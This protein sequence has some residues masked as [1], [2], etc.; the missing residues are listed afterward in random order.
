M[1]GS[2]LK[3]AARTWLQSKGRHWTEWSYARFCTELRAAVQA[4]VALHT[5]EL[6]E[7]RHTGS[8]A[9]FNRE[10]QLLAAGAEEHMG[11]VY[12]RDVYLDKVRPRELANFLRVKDE[13]N[14]Q[15]L[16]ATAASLAPNFARKESERQRCEKCGR[17]HPRGAPCYGPNYEPRGAAGTSSRPWK[18]AGDR[19]RDGNRG[20]RRDYTRGE[21]R[22]PRVM[23][24]EVEAASE[25]D[26]TAASG[27]ACSQG[28]CEE[29]H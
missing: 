28:G 29:G 21:R 26:G 11:P 17:W 15:R 10:F 25:G 8:I 16:M 3:G 7:L 23:E 14:L 1:L 9:A 27:D 18:S 13:A 2:R 6:L 24:A 22:T 5:R 12:V 4:D 20:E 19:E